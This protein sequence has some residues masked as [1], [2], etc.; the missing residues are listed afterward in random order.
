IRFVLRKHRNL[1][2]LKPSLSGRSSALS[3]L[4]GVESTVSSA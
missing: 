2:L 4:F 1:F 3:V